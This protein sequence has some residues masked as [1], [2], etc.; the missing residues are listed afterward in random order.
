M[1]VAGCDSGLSAVALRHDPALRFDALEVFGEEPFS[2]VSKKEAPRY[3]EK[4]QQLNVY[5]MSMAG[6]MLNQYIKGEERSFTII[7]YPLP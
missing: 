6:Q 4:Q 2:P 7:A 1:L 5:E 3:N